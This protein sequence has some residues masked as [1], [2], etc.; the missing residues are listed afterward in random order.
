MCKAI[1]QSLRGK[2]RYDIGTKV[3]TTEDLYDV[4]V[5]SERANVGTLDRAWQIVNMEL[6]SFEKVSFISSKKAPVHLSVMKEVLEHIITTKNA[7][8]QEAKKK[9]EKAAL[10]KR[11]NEA[12]AL[13]EE[14]SLLSGDLDDLKNRLKALEDD[15]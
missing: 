2:Y 15:D 5:T 9:K 14:E 11:I 7:E 13:K 1:E 6:K 12:I 3:V 8:A 10:R 4:P